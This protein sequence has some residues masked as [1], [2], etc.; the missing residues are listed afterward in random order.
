MKKSKVTPKLYVI[1]YKTNKR[2]FT[3]HVDYVHA[4]SLAEA[5]RKFNFNSKYHIVR[6]R[7]I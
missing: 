2:E 1:Y 5:K 7:V 6:E 3:V 4:D